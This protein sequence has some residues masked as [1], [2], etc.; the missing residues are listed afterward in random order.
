MPA[1]MR[2]RVDFPQPEFADQPQSLALVDPE[3]Q[4]IDGMHRARLDGAAQSRRNP[5]AHGKPWLTWREPLGY[6]LDLDEGAHAAI[7]AASG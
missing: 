6:L 5:L 2:P 1:M 4:S 7:S 3:R